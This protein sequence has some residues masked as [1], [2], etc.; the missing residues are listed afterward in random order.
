MTELKQLKSILARVHK[1]QQKLHHILAKKSGGVRSGGVRSGGFIGLAKKRGG[2]CK[3]KGSS[4]PTGGRRGRPRKAGGVLSGGVLSGG[5][6]SGGRKRG[7]PR[8]VGGAMGSF[9]GG[10]MG[11]FTGGRRPRGKKGGAIGD[12]TGGAKR[13]KP[14][15]KVHN[16][17]MVFR[18]KFAKAHP[19]LSPIECSK[20][21]GIAYRAMK[22]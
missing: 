12:F 13:R 18:A 10:A 22:H 3:C 21:A 1:E 2:I 19:N 9:T 15:A 16:P 17:F 4:M 6:L 14:R 20:Q 5:M 11:D 7:R 8:K